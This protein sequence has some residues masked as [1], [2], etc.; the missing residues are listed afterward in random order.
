[1]PSP[2]GNLDR[3]SGFADLYD[4]HRPAPPARLGGV[5]AAYAG[6]DRPEVV[7]LGSGT[8][9]SSRW[10]AVWASQVVGVEPN[11]DMRA[12]AESRPLPNVR[13]VAGTSDATGLTDASADVVIAVQAMHWMDPVPT[14][15]EVARV[16]RTG[17][18]FA[19]VDADWPP[20]TGAALA[21]RA[22]ATVHG[23]M[24]VFEARLSRGESGAALHRPVED[25]D[26]ALADDDLHDP[27][28]NRALPGGVRSWSK[29]EHLARLRHSGRY[30][31]TREL[32]FDEP[33]DGGAA[34]VVALMRSQ[35]S[36]QQLRRAGIDD[37]EIGMPAFE[38]DVAASVPEHATIAFSWRVR[39]GVIG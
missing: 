22:W 19:I 29:G 34:R 4:A 39:L 13:Y 3:F 31:F 11:P 33:A 5:L 26:P 12:Q 37:D 28:R 14:H 2:G 30:V 18:V 32:L 24:R 21:E 7:D 10:A 20:V 9:L 15:A 17:G 25:D 6:V 35:G 16:L 1:M 27:H 23:R 8:G 36:Y 38:A